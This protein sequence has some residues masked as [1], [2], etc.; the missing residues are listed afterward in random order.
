MSL[1]LNVPTLKLSNICKVIDI[2]SFSSQLYGIIIDYLLI[3]AKVAPKQYPGVTLIS[4]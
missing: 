4:K 2:Q 3:L 1:V